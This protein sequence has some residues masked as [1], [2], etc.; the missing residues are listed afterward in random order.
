MTLA[1]IALGS[2]LASPAGS[3]EAT[4]TA[5]AERLAELGRI[6]ARSSLYSTAPV[7]FADQPRFVNAVVAMETGLAP[8]ALLNA[9]LALEL[10]FGRN[11]V[12]AAPNGPRVLDLDLLFYGDL[13]LAEANLAV[14]HPRLAERAFVLVPLAEIAPDLRDPRCGKTV[15]QLLPA[16]AGHA[17]ADA[18]QDAVVKM[19]SRAW[20]SPVQRAEG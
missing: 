14:P 2:N 3:P 8:Q 6:T 18:A 5:A 4:L 17:A 12:G 15:A 20:D 13:V 9:L 7:G 11:R 16:L 19:A 1:F 10:A